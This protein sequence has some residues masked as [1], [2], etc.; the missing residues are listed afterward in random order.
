MKTIDEVVKKKFRHLSDQDLIR[1]ANNAPD[2]CWD[3]EACE[4]DRRR[5]ENGLKVKMEYNTL[6]ILN[7]Q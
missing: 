7:D 5:R 6:V 1:R 4:I 3:D 2:F